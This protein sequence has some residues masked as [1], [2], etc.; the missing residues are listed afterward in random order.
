[1]ILSKR[2]ANETE[3]IKGRITDANTKTRSALLG[4]HAGEK[5]IIRDC[6][7]NDSGPGHWSKHRDL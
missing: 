3:I 7:N 2:A 1:M 5:T 6:R 4:A